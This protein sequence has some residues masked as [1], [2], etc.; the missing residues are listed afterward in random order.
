MSARVFISQ[1][2]R[3]SKNHGAVHRSSGL[4]Y[5][6]YAKH[7]RTTLTLMNHFKHKND[8]EVAL[9]ASLRDM[10]GHLMFRQPLSFSEGD[11]VNFSPMIEGQD[12]FE[13]SLEI[14]AFSAVDLKIPFTAIA[15]LY[16]T[17]QTAS[18]VHAYGRVYSSH[19]IEDGRIVP[20]GREAG[21]TLRDSD[22]VRS[23]AVFHN[24][25]ALHPEQ[26]IQLEVRNQKGDMRQAE[27]DLEPLS[28]FATVKIYP[29][30][31]I[32]DLTAFLAGGDGTANLGFSVNGAFTR[33][34]VGNETVD[35]HQL[36]VTHS[37]FNYADHETEALPGNVET[38][39]MVVP[40][41][42][43]L[44]KVVCVYPECSPGAYT[45]RL[46]DREVEFES[47]QPVQE[48]APGGVVDFSRQD[49][50]LP[51]RLVTGLILGDAEQ[52]LSSECSL[53]VFHAKRPDKRLSWGVCA[54]PS[55]LDARLVV[56]VLS[57]I[58]GPLPDDV[59]ATL[60][61]YSAN[62][63]ESLSVTLDKDQLCRLEE[64]QSFADLV[65]GLEQHLGGD[66]GYYTLFSEYGGLVCYTLIQSDTQ[67][68][69]IEHSF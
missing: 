16:E 26:K 21:W 49:G 17:Q 6:R 15:A 64:G 62:N 24:G 32:A 54:A 3:F 69:S 18:L 37:N 10:S 40:S 35:G 60:S 11:V 13:G 61:I 51:A 12:T 67:A 50:A 44:R 57:P 14:E 19:E 53:G 48:V 25:A 28:P 38:A 65:P 41:L 43:G 5:Y 1:S 59:L 66:L 63:Q 20:V 33:M 30:D 36:H 29:R 55:R 9:V 7:D 68:P 2:D 46:A 34:L 8:A 47:G 39:H 45:M 4:F 52:V 23:F 56:T 58:K 42:G 31:H 27:I 22:A